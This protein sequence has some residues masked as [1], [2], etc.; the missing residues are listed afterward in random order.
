MRTLDNVRGPS[1]G[2]SRVVEEEE[3]EVHAGEQRREG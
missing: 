3:K 2:Y 1:P